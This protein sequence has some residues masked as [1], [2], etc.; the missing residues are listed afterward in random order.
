M[1]S[2]KKEDPHIDVVFVILG[3]EF[4]LRLN[5]HR[6]IKGAVEEIL[7]KSQNV[8]QPIS[9]WELRTHDGRLLDMEKSFLEE[10][11]DKDIKLYLSVKVGRG[12]K[13]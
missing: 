3:K 12:G 7:A 11:I 2:E 8:G 1:A 13:E 9:N 10:G 4:P 6:K 5:P